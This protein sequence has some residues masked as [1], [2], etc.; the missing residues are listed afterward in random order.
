M[1]FYTWIGWTG[2]VLALG[3]YGL[4]A[5]GFISET[6]FFSLGAVASVLLAYALFKDRAVYGG[7]L[8]AAFILLNLLGIVRIF[9]V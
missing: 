2:T 3:T 7:V 4:F 8:Q 6:W 9:Y 1:S 5:A